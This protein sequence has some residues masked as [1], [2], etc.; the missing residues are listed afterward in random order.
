MFG[1]QVFYGPPPTPEQQL[2]ARAF[3]LTSFLAIDHDKKRAEAQ[4]ELDRINA[5]LAALKVPE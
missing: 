3:A 4:A 5:A 2:T 1:Q